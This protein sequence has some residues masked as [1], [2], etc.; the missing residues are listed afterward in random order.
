M[1]E[2]KVDSRRR[3]SV[4]VKWETVEETEEAEAKANI[5]EAKRVEECLRAAAVAD[6]ARAAS[7][8][9]GTSTMASRG[10]RS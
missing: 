9:W 6:E 1:E 7:D 8:L 10:N 4:V 5:R 2:P 3:D